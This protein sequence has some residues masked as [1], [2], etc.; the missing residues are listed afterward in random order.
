MSLEFTIS[1]VS[2][3]CAEDDLYIIVKDKVYDA[4]SFL[5]EHP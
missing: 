1:D 4:T 3:H 2:H 5:E